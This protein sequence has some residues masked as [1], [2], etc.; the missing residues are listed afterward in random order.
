VTIQTRGEGSRFLRFVL[1]GGIAAAANICSR[2]AFNWLTTA[3]I[4]AR[5]YVFEPASDNPVQQYIRF[6][7]VNVVAFAQVWLVSVCLVRW[8][9]PAVGYT[10]NAELVAHMIGVVSPV[11]TS[12]FAHKYFSF[13]SGD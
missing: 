4:L 12:F 2:L 3:F 13:K 11:F 6:G 7:L 5:K 9:F 10:W 8:L 1:T